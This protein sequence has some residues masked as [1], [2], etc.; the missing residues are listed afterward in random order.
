MNKLI[1]IIFENFDIPYILSIIILTYM[2][3]KFIDYFNGDKKVS[4]LLK[5]IILLSCT[6]ILAIAYKL[7]TDIDNYILINSSICAPVIY[8]WVIKPIVEKIG[9]GYKK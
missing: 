1:D 2:V 8:S 7:F 6:F 3:I 9:V 4:C 5:R